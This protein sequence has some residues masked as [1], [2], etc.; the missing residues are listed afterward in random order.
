MEL[1]P[2]KI[3]FF[4][5]MKTYFFCVVRCGT[6]SLSRRVPCPLLKVVLEAKTRPPPK[7]CFLFFILFV[8][9]IF[10]YLFFF[11]FRLIKIWPIFSILGYLNAF[12]C[13]FVAK[14]PL[15]FAKLNSIPLNRARGPLNDRCG[16]TRSLSTTVRCWRTLPPSTPWEFGRPLA[17]QG[18]PCYASCFFN[19]SSMT[20]V[21]S[22]TWKP[23]AFPCLS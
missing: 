21:G 7:I 11:Y 14:L 12:C 6:R 2:P 15:T 19:R 3:V 4:S 5:P 23:R 17:W 9:F 22:K 18:R 1:G 13:L 8:L 20:V 10:I 16:S